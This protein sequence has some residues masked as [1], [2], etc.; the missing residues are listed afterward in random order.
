MN[1]LEARP[2]VTL[3]MPVKNG[4]RY[5]KKSIQTLISALGQNDE[6]LI[7]NDGSS[8]NTRAIALNICKESSNVRLLDSIN[9]GL[10]NSLNFGLVNSQHQLIARVDVDDEYASNRIEKQL[11]VFG[12]DTVAVFSDYRFFAEGRGNL[13]LIYSAIHPVAT[14]LSLITSQRTAHPS[15]IVNRDAILEVGGYREEDFPA[16]DLSLWLRLS[17]IGAIRTVP[18]TLLNYRINPLGI[19]STK[20]REMLQKK[21][22]LIME[23]GIN[24]SDMNKLN[25]SFSEILDIYRDNPNCSERKILFA[26]DLLKVSLIKPEYRRALYDAVSL[27]VPELAKGT[28]LPLVYKFHRERIERAKFR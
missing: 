5:L 18:F 22:S 10:V 6:I 13:G 16:E 15:V 25:S 3:L 8:D 28:F 1:Q 17:R 21:T 20:R 4:E 2:P 26:R 12:Q 7:I 23:I 19:S 11:E 14:S 24:P 9:Q 27:I